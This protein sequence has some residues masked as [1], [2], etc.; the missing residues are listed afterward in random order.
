ML[1]RSLRGSK[2]RKTS[3]PFLA[4]CLMKSSTTSSAKFRFETRFWPRIRAWIGVFGVAYGDG[5][6]RNGR[7]HLDERVERVDAAQVLRRDGDS[8][9]GQIRP[10]CDDT[11]Q[12]RRA[13]GRGD[14]HLDSPFARARR[15]LHDPTR[16]AVRGAHLDLMRQSEIVE[17]FDARL[18][19]RQ[20]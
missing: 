20:I 5:G 6:D 14:H 4:A 12:M 3:T 1:R 19:Q 18:H 8:D 2:T 16:I 11:W 15:P 9:H 10:G 13:A 17:H 7:W